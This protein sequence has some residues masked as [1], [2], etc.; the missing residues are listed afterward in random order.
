MDKDMQGIYQE[1]EESGQLSFIDT[2]DDNYFP[3]SSDYGKI[4]NRFIERYGNISYLANLGMMLA[5]QKVER[6]N[7]ELYRGTKEGMFYDEIFKKTGAD[8]SDGLVACI[9][10]NQFLKLYNLGSGGHTYQALDELYN[11]TMLRNQWQILYEDKDIIAS[12]AV[13]TA[14]A[15]DKVHKNLLMKFN[16]DLDSVILNIQKDYAQISLPVLGKLREDYIT[17][18]YQLFKKRYDSEQAKN[19]KYGYLFQNE[20]KIDFDLDQFYF[21]IGLYPIDLTTNDEDMK[22]VVELLRMK[23]YDAAAKIMRE[24]GLVGKYSKTDSRSLALD[25]FSYFK[26]HYLDKAFKRI[27]GFNV[28]KKLEKPGTEEFAK[29]LS[30]YEKNCRS[31]HPTDIHFRYEILRSGRGGKAT[32]CRFYISKAEWMKAEEI[33][34]DKPK[35]QEQEEEIGIAQMKVI[36]EVEGLLSEEKLS[37]QDIKSIAKKADWNIETVRKAYQVAKEKPRQNIVGFMIKAI[38]GK[39]EPAVVSKAEDDAAAEEY[40]YEFLAEKIGYDDAMMMQPMYKSTLLA[41]MDVIYDTMNS[42]VSR[43]KVGSG[44]LPAA[45]VKKRLLELD[46]LCL[47]DAVRMFL[48]NSR[49]SGIVQDSYIVTI[50]YNIRKQTELKLDQDLQKNEGAF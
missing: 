31:I 25:D 46:S 20:I 49:E 37:D 34:V 4:P 27:N 47:C 13:L 12:V 29:A 50:L 17:S 40:S 48:N 35:E 9:P 42:D 15:Y 22:K 33:V 44:T 32:G 36:I 6:R 41:F 24:K 8:F 30:E 26:R 21:I 10:I 16:G 2:D 43:I 5:I 38:E 1:E 23:D 11:G 39:W 45:A 19:K 18:I 3:V 28:I 7:H 14:T